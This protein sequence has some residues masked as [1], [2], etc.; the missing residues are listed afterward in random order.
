MGTQVN[1]LFVCLGNIVRSP[2]A[3]NIFRQLAAQSGVGS[4]YRVDSAGTS[5]WHLGE[6]PDARMRR[7]AAQHGL[8][9]QGHARQVNRQD[10][11]KFDLIIAMDRDNRAI[12]YSLAQ[13]A[14]QQEKIHLLREFDPQGQYNS[15]VPD[16]YYGGVD[17]FEETYH[18]VE[19]SCQSLLEAL[20]TG[21]LVR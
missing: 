7:V 15:E 12:L 9:Y 5:S 10:L 4:K 8:H 3:E 14:S 16:P 2:L 11:E 18:I 21:R 6:S 13:G 19:R 1:I 17:G 20:E